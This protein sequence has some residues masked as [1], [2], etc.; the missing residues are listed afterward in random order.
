[1]CFIYSSITKRKLLHFRYSQLVQYSTMN[2]L[3]PQDRAIL[4]S[5]FNPLLPLGEGVMDDASI[6]TPDGKM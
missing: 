5:M 3:S 4:N 6:D 2:E 1:M